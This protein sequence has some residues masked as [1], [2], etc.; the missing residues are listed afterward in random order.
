[1]EAR[2]VFLEGKRKGEILALSEQ[3]TTIGRGAENT[4]TI[5]DDSVSRR[6][7]II[8]I[9]DDQFEIRD[10]NSTNGTF[11]NGV[12]IAEVST[13]SYGDEIRIGHSRL[14]FTSSEAQDFNGYG[15]WVN[16]ISFVDEKALEESS[17][18][19]LQ[20]D[21]GATKIL[22][23]KALFETTREHRAVRDLVTIYR[24]GNAIHSIQD[25]SQLL[26][27]VLDLVFEVVEAD[28]GII[29]L[30]EDGTE[31]LVPKVSR[32]RLP[33]RRKKRLAISHS[34]ARRVLEG[35]TSIL[36]GDALFDERFKNEESV[37]INGI[38]SAICVPLRGKNRVVG[39]L[40]ADNHREKQAFEEADLRLLTAIGIQA[41]IAIENILLFE[42]KK[43]LLLGSIKALVASEEARDPYTRGHSERVAANSVAI[44]RELK[45]DDETISR[46]ELAAL[47]HDV[48]KVGI[49]DNILRK[50]SL[51]DSTEMELIRMHSTKGAEI[52]GHIK[53]VEEIA[54][55]V[56]HHHERFDGSGYPDG[57]ASTQIPLASRIIALADAYD[58]M[59]SDRPYRAA[60][61]RE[62]TLKE[63]RKAA[64]AQFDEE[65]VRIFTSIIKRG[66]A[67]IENGTQV[68]EEPAYTHLKDTT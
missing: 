16:D 1:V 64:G 20:I 34:I 46:I 18:F 31:K 36:T 27:T 4:V 23:T 40:Y 6:H 57:L 63:I 26:Q 2:L 32:S 17:V 22:D 30:I 29:M 42:D 51:I 8:Q 28:T 13:L 54:K 67:R 24:V 10:L 53:G 65:L 52:I 14:L 9:S 19:E 3:R 25:L 43:E 21:K 44:A 47:L 58:A 15:K 5:D 48:G 56:R 33:G 60:M 66:G 68:S 37:F 38:R 35:G 50:G 41:G 12:R 55:A 11:L 49:P 62:E 59:T 7:C 61:S 39:L 45:L